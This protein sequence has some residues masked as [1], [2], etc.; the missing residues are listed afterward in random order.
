MDQ[1]IIMVMIWI[2]EV[3]FIKIKV[4]KLIMVMVITLVN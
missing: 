3:N 2:M 4:I 1:M